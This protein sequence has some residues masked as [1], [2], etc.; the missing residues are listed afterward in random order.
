MRE[1]AIAHALALAL[2]PAAL[3]VLDGFRDALGPEQ[4]RIVALLEGSDAVVER[5]TRELRSVLGAA[6]VAETRLLDGAD[7]ARAY[8]R[9]V[10]AYA[11]ST[12]ADDVTLLARGLPV[13]GGSA[14]GRGAP[15][16]R[17]RGDDRRSPYR[18]RRRAYARRRRRGTC[19]ARTRERPGRRYA[20]RGRRVGRCA[21]VARHDAR[22]QGALRPEGR[23]RARPIRRRDLTCR[24]SPRR[25][26]CDLRRTLRAV[27]SRPSRVRRLVALGPRGWA[28]TIALPR[29]RAA[30]GWARAGRDPHARAAHSGRG[31]ARTSARVDRRQS[32]SRAGRL[33]S[34]HVPAGRDGTPVRRNRRRARDDLRLPRQPLRPAPGR[35]AGRVRDAA[36][37]ADRRA[38]RTPHADRL[39]PR[40]PARRRR[41]LSAL[42]GRRRARRSARAAELRGGARPRGR[43]GAVL[44]RNAGAQAP[45]G[46]RARARVRRL[47]RVAIA[48]AFRDLRGGSSPPRA[49]R[50]CPCS[51]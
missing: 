18:R 48:S 31:A 42:A 35:A 50:R 40:R 27:F 4:P 14:R 44:R 1:R 32:V 3:L 39:L 28:S 5:T 6:G 10:D 23:A 22:A 13:R 37:G 46:R 25:S 2:E 8:Q 21:G 43:R 45:P 19:G 26:C 15:R 29:A 24:A 12:F 7:A 30:R 11:T 47:V 51:R 17:R 38:R 33:H 9:I 16:A 41:R 20:A 49:A 34:R 36:R